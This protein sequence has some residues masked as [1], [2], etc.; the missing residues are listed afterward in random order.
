MAA[1]GPA[2]AAPTN[3]PATSPPPTAPNAFNIRLNTVVMHMRDVREI[4]RNK[5]EAKRR[6]QRIE[7]LRARLQGD[8]REVFFAAAELES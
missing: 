7:A 5:W 1:A 3:S 4:N 6:E 8:P 2:R